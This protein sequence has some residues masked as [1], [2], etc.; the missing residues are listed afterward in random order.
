LE[1]EKNT[2]FWHSEFCIEQMLVTLSMRIE[3]VTKGEFSVQDLKDDIFDKR[4][5]WVLWSDI[6]IRL[7]TRKMN[8]CGVFFPTG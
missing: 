2:K 5:C 8:Q 6:D 1:A 3:P 7:G 4:N